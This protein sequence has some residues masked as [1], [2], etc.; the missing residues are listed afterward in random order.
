MFG[1]KFSVQ[2]LFDRTVSGFGLV[3]FGWIEMTYFHLNQQGLPT[4]A[5]TTGQPRLFTVPWYHTPT[6][7]DAPR[8]HNPVPAPRSAV[9]CVCLKRDLVGVKAVGMYA[10][11]LFSG[12]YS[13]YFIP[14]SARTPKTPMSH[15]RYPQEINCLGKVV[16]ELTI[17]SS[18]ELLSGHRA[19]RTINFLWYVSTCAPRNG[20]QQPTRTRT[21]TPLG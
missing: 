1:T 15:A 13:D 21:I 10:C 19:V 5:P 11:T 3:L 2:T 20:R 17:E 12:Y 14:R 9:L 18:R 6:R 7:T 16:R 4:R 8:F